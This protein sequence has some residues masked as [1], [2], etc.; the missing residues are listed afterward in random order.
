MDHLAQFI[1]TARQDARIAAYNNHQL[2]QSVV[3]K[4]LYLLGWDAFNVSEVVADYQAG[5]MTIDF[6]L[7]TPEHGP[8]FL[9]I[10]KP[11][12]EKSVELQEKVIKTAAGNEVKLAVLTDGLRWHL[13]VATPHAPLH[14]KEFAK[15]D[16]A[17][18]D[19]E[20]LSS[21]LKR[22][23][24]HRLALSG[25]AF[26]R[27]EKTFS[28]RVKRKQKLFSTALTDAWTRL[29]TEAKVV[30][31]ELLVIEVKRVAGKQI[32]VAVAERFYSAFASIAAQ[33]DA[34]KKARYD[35]VD[36]D[37]DVM[38]AWGGL[39]KQLQELLSELVTN[40]IEREH[41]FRADKESVEAFL[42]TVQNLHDNASGEKARA[43]KQA[44]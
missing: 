25:T 13:F 32:D 12:N 26:T 3:L 9:H 41:N 19:P 35:A 7:Q 8:I 2:K 17:E 31:V 5:G 6:A 28:E 36:A 1:N 15:I 29:V 34:N 23:L 43:R 38:R 40:D 14:D 39:L 44:V 20:E 27:A 4:V 21:T 42:V 22:F 11:L 16:F 24:S 10:V 18:G 30:F 37:I 33:S